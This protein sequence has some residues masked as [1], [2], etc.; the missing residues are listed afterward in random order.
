MKLDIGVVY[1][2]DIEKFFLKIN[3]FANVAKAFPKEA[4]QRQKSYLNRNVRE[5]NY[6]I[7]E[8]VRT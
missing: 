4:S 8:S 1:A 7:G 6:E 2:R 5:T 3:V